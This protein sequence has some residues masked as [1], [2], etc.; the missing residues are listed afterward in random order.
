MKGAYIFHNRVDT[1][2][3]DLKD[4][5]DIVSRPIDFGS[6]KQ[7]LSYNQ[8]KSKA[9]FLEDIDL[10]FSNC[11]LYNGETSEIGLIAMNIRREYESVLQQS[12]FR[13]N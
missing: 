7:K 3:L 4:Y 2:K 11:I 12:D 13:Q 9:Q 8:Y 5:G 1:S 10:T 6:I